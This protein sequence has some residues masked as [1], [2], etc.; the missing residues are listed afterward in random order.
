MGELH[1]ISGVLISLGAIDATS[2]ELVSEFEEI[3]EEFNSGDDVK[4]SYALMGLLA[5]KAI[6]LCR[7]LEG[8][9][10]AAASGDRGRDSDGPTDR[11]PPARPGA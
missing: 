7:Q 2:D 11:V 8:G 9:Q 1:P 4:R 3:D 6:K 5:L 10:D